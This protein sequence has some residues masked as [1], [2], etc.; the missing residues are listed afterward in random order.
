VRFEG[1]EGD[2][3]KNAEQYVDLYKR[4][5]DAKLSVRWRRSL[6][7][8]A[9][10]QIQLSLQPFGYYNA[11]IESSLQEDQDR[12]IAVYKVDPGPPVKIAK[13]TI[14]WSGDGA[15]RPELHQE[16]TKFPLKQGDIFVHKT[17][18]DGKARLHDAAYELGYVKVKTA[19]HVVRVYPARN[20]A[21]I[22][23]RLNTGPLYRFGAITLHQDIIDP[24]LLQQYVT[25][26]QGDAYSNQDLLQ[27]Q[28][29]LI[30]SGW[31]SVA[32]I[33]PD[34]DAAQDAEVPIDVQFTPGKKHHVEF[35]LGYE[36]DVGV[37][38]SARWRNKRVN[39]KGHQA[40][41][42]LQLAQVKGNAG[43]NYD[44]PI[45]NPRTDRL[46]FGSNYE[47]EDVN[48]S[49]RNTLNLEASLIR[50]SLD[51]KDFFKLLSE[52][53][54][55]RFS[56]G[57]QQDTVTKLLSIGGMASRT[58]A[59]EALF[60]RSGYFVSADLRV[61]TSALLSDTSFIRGHFVAKY[62]HPIGKQG[63]LNL[64]AEV[65]GSW[66]EDFEKY[67]NS[68]R[69]FAGGDMSVRGY[70]YKD[71]GPKDDSGSN[72]GGKNLLVGSIEY[73]H[74]IVGNWTGAAFVDAGNAYNNELDKIY[75]GSGVGIRW[76]APFG[77]IR[78]DVGWPVS[79]NAEVSDVQL[80][81]GLGAVL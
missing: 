69:F 47:Y 18:E 66:V 33:K 8:D 5:D 13:T 23:L 15:E 48:D 9:P 31:F 41:A 7:Q 59:E 70:A 64:R 44:I 54:Y 32:Q 34:F 12:W 80:H 56:S 14:Q 68:L 38:G 16:L 51:K 4:Q 10:E 58:V 19:E 61:S 71:L 29:G 49:S 26:R 78:V 76:L 42:Q 40:G 72:I 53:K 55:E 45:N 25:L 73:D 22:E 67:P 52:Y 21:S 60:V 37:R 65:G 17:Y 81:I 6:H 1:L 36:T 28:Q 46:S 24:E 50:S 77:N 20:E 30:A 63:R 43:A 62:L 11:I 2:M 79:E 3:L 74:R 35:G 27:F 57:L 39:R 75:I